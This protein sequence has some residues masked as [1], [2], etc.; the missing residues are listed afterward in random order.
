MKINYHVHTNYTSDAVPTVAQVCA[1]AA[2]LGFDEICITNHQ[3]WMD[4]LNGD[5]KHYLTAAEWKQAITEITSARKRY[6]SMNIKLGVEMGYLEGHVD[7]MR[8]FLKRYPFDYIIGSVHC[9]NGKF[10]HECIG[11]EPRWLY[12][13]YYGLLKQMVD[14]NYCD[15][16]GHFDVIKRHIPFDD[17]DSY[18][19]LVE[20]VI[21]A[22]KKKGIGFELNTMGWHYDSQDSHPSR[23]ILEMLYGAGIRKVTI[24]TDAHRVE[25]LEYRMNEGLNLLKD[26][27]FREIC[28][29]SGR[30]AEFHKL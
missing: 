25:E 22:M 6:P 18:K 20:A 5:K 13:Q 27:G 3:E 11:L 29:F 8:G 7:E 4:V 19:K 28:T 2:E 1:R 26:V 15:C 23:Q 17:S 12:K 30:K 10:L 21:N 14:A 16:I 24:G 9:I